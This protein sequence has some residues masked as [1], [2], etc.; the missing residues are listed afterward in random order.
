[1]L[2]VEYTVEMLVQKLNVFRRTGRRLC[3]VIVEG[4]ISNN[5]RRED[6]GTDNCSNNMIS[7][8]PVTLF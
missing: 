7:S 8:A 5:L 1:M 4:G 3:Y 6:K 2:P